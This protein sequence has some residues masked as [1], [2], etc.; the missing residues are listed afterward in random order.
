MTFEEF[1][2]LALNPP[3]RNVPVI[4]RLDVFIMDDLPVHRKCYYPKF[5]VSQYKEIF[6]K[7][8]SQAETIIQKLVRKKDKEGNL[9]AFYLKELP[10]GKD[11]SYCSASCR[12]YDGKGILIEQSRCSS[13]D[14]DIHGYYGSFRGRTSEQTRFKKGDIVEVFECGKVQLAIVVGVPNSIERCWDFRNSGSKYIP[15]SEN[16]RLTVEEWKDKLYRLDY[17]DDC[18][19][20]IDGPGYYFHSHILSESLFK[21]RFPI[22][23]RVRRRFES[24]YVSML[25]EVE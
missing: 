1:K 11:V 2:Q 25:K 17:S 10:F 22:S 15:R 4:F 12:V 3:R 5:S 8:V 20:V 14:E 13:L 18:Y 6:C 19:I 23:S 24:F 21:P 7:T 9:Y 16:S